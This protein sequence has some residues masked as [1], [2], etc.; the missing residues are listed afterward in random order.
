MRLRGSG[1][2]G[3]SPSPPKAL[4]TPTFPLPTIRRM[5]DSYCEMDLKFSEN[6]ALRGEYVGGSAKVRM[7]RLM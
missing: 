4:K 5:E 6:E 1:V 2:Y 7:G 3:G